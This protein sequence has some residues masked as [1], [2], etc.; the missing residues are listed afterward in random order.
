MI[1]RARL[2]ALDENRVLHLR[3]KTEQRPTLNF[4]FGDKAAGNMAPRTKVEIRSVI[5]DEQNGRC[6][7]RRPRHA[8]L[9]AQKP[10]TGLVQR[11]RDYKGMVRKD[12]FIDQRDRNIEYDHKQEHGIIPSPDAVVSM[13]SNL[14]MRSLWQNY[15]HNHSGPISLVLILSAQARRKGI[16]GKETLCQHHF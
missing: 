2:P 10:Q 1:R 7:G 11:M 5:G 6:Y 9:N 12:A 4:G 15:A 8:Y 3:Q 16:I 14:F 13:S